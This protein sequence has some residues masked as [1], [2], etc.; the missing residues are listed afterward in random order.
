MTDKNEQLNEN[1][2]KYEIGYL[3]KE[4]SDIEEIRKLLENYKAGI[5]NEGRPRKIRLAYPIKKE[6]VANFGYIRFFLDSNFVG[7][8]DKKLKLSQNAIRFL[9]LDLTGVKEEKPEV[10][11]K[12]EKHIPTPRIIEEPV[13]KTNK[14]EIIDNEQLEKKLEEILK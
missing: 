10:E 1:L 13:R 9:I 8:I 12:I 11:N 6:T 14:L 5:I 4:E 7:D 3:V 2:K